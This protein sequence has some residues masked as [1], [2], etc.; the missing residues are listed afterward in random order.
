MSAVRQD[1]TECQAS[2]ESIYNKIWIV[3]ILALNKGV[4]CLKNSISINKQE[5]CSNSYR[6]LF[7]YWKDTDGD[8]VV[9]IKF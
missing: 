3:Y 6:V 8:M 7:I 9:H 1:L 5:T 2:I 4:R